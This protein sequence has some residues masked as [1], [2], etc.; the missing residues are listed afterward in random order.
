MKKNSLL[1]LIGIL[2]GLAV[3]SL[4]IMPVSFAGDVLKIT[5]EELQKILSDS[6]VVILDVRQGKDWKSS[7]F[8]I[9]GAI[10]ENP[11]KL[12]AWIAKYPKNKKF[13]LYCA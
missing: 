7:E 13:V 4:F 10:R 2:T 5:K 8:K 1:R 6:D 3:I 11:N 9:K 12:D